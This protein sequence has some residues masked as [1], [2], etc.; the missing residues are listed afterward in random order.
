MTPRPSRGLGRG[1]AALIPDSALEMD[2]M[3]AERGALR[4][5]AI[6]PTVSPTAMSPTTTDVPSPASRTAWR[7]PASRTNAR[8]P[9]SPCRISTPPR[10]RS[11]QSDS[12]SRSA[13]A[14]ASRDPKRAAAPHGGEDHHDD[15]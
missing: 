11:I 13:M 9:S 10:F 4:K 2:V 8:S 5:S 12:R 15:Y 6:S 3:P 1:L 7:R 14:S